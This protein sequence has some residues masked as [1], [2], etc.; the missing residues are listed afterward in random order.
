MFSRNDKQGVQENIKTDDSQEKGMDGL[1]TFL[2]RIIP[3]L[4]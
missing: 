3:K 2:K 1:C 4:I